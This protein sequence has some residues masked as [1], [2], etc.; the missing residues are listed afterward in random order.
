MFGRSA[1]NL[2]S[3]LV[4][5]QGFTA[6]PVMGDTVALFNAAGHGNDAAVASVIDVA[7]LGLAR[8]LMRAQ[9]GL[10]GV[11]RLNLAPRYLIVPASRETVAQQ[12]TNSTMVPALPGSVNPF[13]GALQ[14]ICE[15]RLDGASLTAWYLAADPT[16]IDLIE[17]AYLEGENGPRV[18]SRVGFDVEGVE[19]KCGHDVA[20]KA[21]DWRGFVRNT[22]V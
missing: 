20:A 13:A 1:R 22:G 19:I 21:M 10:D 4:W 8:G 18:E 6:N 7:N 5:A 16:Q 11:T 14:V 17:L 3:D 12:M 15:A 2:E 9:T